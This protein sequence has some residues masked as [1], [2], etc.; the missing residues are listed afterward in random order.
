MKGQGPPCSDDTFNPSLQ[1]V[2]WDTIVSKSVLWT[3]SLTYAEETEYQKVK[4]PARGQVAACIKELQV[5]K[6]WFTIFI[7]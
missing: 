2:S 3:N 6:S 7:Y 1:E 5:S 4:E